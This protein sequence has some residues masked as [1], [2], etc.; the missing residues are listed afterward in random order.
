MW[1]TVALAVAGVHLTGAAISPKRASGPVEL[2]SGVLSIRYYAESFTVYRAGEE[3]LHSVPTAGKPTIE[4]AS[5]DGAV[6]TLVRVGQLATRSGTDVLGPYQALEVGWG[7]PAA[8]E[9]ANETDEPVLLTSIRGYNNPGSSEGMLVFAQDWPQGWVQ[10][11]AV[12]GSAS[13][14][15]APFPSLSTGSTGGAG[16]QLNFLAFGGCQLASDPSNR[17]CSVLPLEPPDL[18]RGH[19]CV[20]YAASPAVDFNCKQPSDHSK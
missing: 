6:T 8:G 9:G 18:P 10:H 16:A 7:L 4:V 13:M 19:R 14:L 12:A 3:W 15:I 17:E 20:F 2:S 11:G 1:Q 5:G